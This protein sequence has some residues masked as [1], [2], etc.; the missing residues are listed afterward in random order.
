MRPAPVALRRASNIT[1]D[2]TGRS[3]AE[4]RRRDEHRE[5]RIGDAE[6]KAAKIDRQEQHVA[7][8]HG[9]RVAR[10]ARETRNA[11][12]AAEPEDRQALHLAGKV[13]AIHQ[14]GIE[15]RDRQSGDRVDHE[16]IDVLERDAGIGDGGERHLLQQLQRM[17]LEYLGARL[18]AVALVVPILRLAGVAALDPGIGIEPVEPREMREHRPRPL[19]DIVLRNFMRGDR[20]RDPGN[21]HVERLRPL[22][23]LFRPGGGFEHGLSSRRRCLGEDYERSALWRARGSKGAASSILRVDRLL[24]CASVC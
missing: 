24:S 17:T 12:A 9:L 10:G 1:E 7:A 15:A 6:A 21:R 8:R 2:D 22:A 23:G 13:E 16:S 18:P 19:G 11:P 3:V 4:Q 5:A 14:H 20:R